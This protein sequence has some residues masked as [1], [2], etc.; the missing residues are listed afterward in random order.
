MGR[1]GSYGSTIKLEPREIPTWTRD[2]PQGSDLRRLLPLQLTP[3]QEIC[4]KALAGLTLKFPD[5]PGFDAQ[6]INGASAPFVQHWEYS[7]N[8]LTAG[9]IAKSLVAKGLVERSQGVYRDSSRQ[10]HA[11]EPGWALTK[12]GRELAGGLL[13]DE[14]FAKYN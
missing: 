13:T 12:A 10:I 8:G 4:L 3:Q 9:P 1:G 5:A 11:D 6:D 2:V 14:H 7:V